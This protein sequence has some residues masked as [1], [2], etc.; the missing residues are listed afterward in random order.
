MEARTAPRTA[1]AVEK[2]RGVPMVYLAWCLAFSALSFVAFGARGPYG[3]YG[4][5]PPSIPGLRRGLAKDPRDCDGSLRQSS[6]Q[7]KWQS[8]TKHAER[9]EPGT[10]SRKQVIQATCG[11]AESEAGS[12]LGQVLGRCQVSCG[13]G[14]SKTRVHQ[15]ANHQGNRRAGTDAR[16]RVRASHSRGTRKPPWGAQ[17]SRGGPGRGSGA[18]GSCYGCRRR[19]IGPRPRWWHRGHGPGRRTATHYRSCPAEKPAYS[20][21]HTSEEGRQL[22]SYDTAAYY[23][24]RCQHQS[25]GP[26]SNSTELRS[27]WDT[28]TGSGT[29]CSRGRSIRGQACT[30]RAQGCQC[31]SA[32]GYHQLLAIERHSAGQ[33][34][35]GPQGLCT[36]RS[37]Q[38]GSSCGWAARNNPGAG[39]CSANYRR[40]FRRTCLG[41]CTWRFAGLRQNGVAHYVLREPFLKTWSASPVGRPAGPR[42]F[43]ISL[44]KSPCFAPPFGQCCCANAIKCSRSR[45]S[46]PEQASCTVFLPLGRPLFLYGSLCT[47]AFLKSDARP[48]HHWNTWTSPLGFCPP[49]SVASSPLEPR[50]SVTCLSFSECRDFFLQHSVFGFSGVDSF[51]RFPAPAVATDWGQR[52][53]SVALGPPPTLYAADFSF[54]SCIAFS[55]SIIFTECAPKMQIGGSGLHAAPVSRAPCTAGSH[56]VSGQGT[57][58]AGTCGM[59]IAILQD[60]LLG[61]FRA[62][63]GVTL[64]ALWGT[65][66]RPLPGRSSPLGR[67]LALPASGV[68]AHVV[69]SLAVASPAR[70]VLLWQPAQRAQTRRKPALALEGSWLRWL[71]A[72]LLG[73]GCFPQQVWAAPILPPACTSV[74]AYFHDMPHA[75]SLD[76]LHEQVRSDHEFWSQTGFQYLSPPLS[77]ARPSPASVQRALAVTIHAP[78]FMPT[79]FGLQVPVGASLEDVMEA[80][81]RLGKVPGPNQN[82]LLPVCRQRF[83][84]SLDLLAFPASIHD[85]MPPHCAVLLDL[86]RVGGHYHAAC[87]PSSCTRQDLL[88]H[89]ARIIWYETTEVDVWVDASELPA[90]HGSL[91]F[92]SG[93]LFTVA[94]RHLGPFRTCTPRQVIESG[95]SWGPLEHAI[96]PRKP[97]GEAAMD[98][99]ASFYMTSS[100]LSPF[101]SEASV[102]K[103]LRLASH[104][105]VLGTDTHLRLDLHGDHCHTVLS[106][107]AEDK[108]WLLDL[109]RLGFAPVVC[110][111]ESQPDAPAVARHLPGQFPDSLKLVCTCETPAPKREFYL[112]IVQVR[113]VPTIGS[114]PAA[115]L[116]GFSLGTPSLRA[117]VATARV[118]EEEEHLPEPLQRIGDP[119]LVVVGP[120]D[121]D[122]TVDNGAEED[123]FWHPTFVVHALDTAPSHYR[124]ALEAP[125]TVERALQELAGVIPIEKYRYFPRLLAAEPQPSQFWAAVLALPP[126]SHSEPLVLL[127]LIALDG[128]C[129]VAPLPNPFTRAQV[130]A[131]ARLEQDHNC[132]VFA[133]NQFVPMNREQ[134]SVM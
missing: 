66:L 16:N 131:A 133:F 96:F 74:P 18:G 50:L 95:E 13:E 127:N 43:E 117:A 62:L 61:F 29:D 108:P 88:D 107:P 129:F 2:R 39:C 8:R 38:Q 64:L 93:S 118:L 53:E 1:A 41:Q 106:G 105:R 15:E 5:G 72:L 14:E 73:F 111:S 10:Q 104:E 123:T 51:E 69:R 25:D 30:P 23:T 17:T 78:H 54:S 114:A 3:L 12:E 76:L 42:S 20:P 122:D 60:Y 55:A 100:L 75:P 86:S 82:V 22:T 116:R 77:G 68:P 37:D 11:A 120:E 48:L 24:D 115:S 103:V 89:I 109:R 59:M 65:L 27:L 94:L 33:A 132:D 91:A 90:Q 52:E 134:K 9:R 87:L 21:Y 40:R 71:L 56:L 19:G 110:F 44:G 49:I 63:C 113:V 80:V 81:I 67:L 26:L 28:G 102:K 101:S 128:R 36:F 119:P 79:Y 84:G 83:N 121:E 112:P 99:H 6:F 32:G 85:I 47:E 31:G 34:P 45:L 58:F 98:S 46:K 130:L 7:A 97:V 4:A 70:P 124:V 125:C 57:G 126:W 35:R 92:T